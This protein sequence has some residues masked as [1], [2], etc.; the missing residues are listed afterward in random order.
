ME[1]STIIR[2]TL[3]LWRVQYWKY[4]TFNRNYYN[5]YKKKKIKDDP[6][7]KYDATL[8]YFVQKCQRNKL[9]IEICT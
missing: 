8:T 9:H 5:S 2:N 6:L 4:F 1:N 7:K 3:W